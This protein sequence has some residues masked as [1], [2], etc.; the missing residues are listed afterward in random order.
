MVTVRNNDGIRV[1]VWYVQYVETVAYYTDNM[2]TFHLEIVVWRD[3][4]PTEQEGV[5]ISGATYNSPRA[6]ASMSEL[7]VSSSPTSVRIPL[8]DSH[9]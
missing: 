6:S 3:M 2:H 1:L 8:R 5:L 9:S 4:S 7:N